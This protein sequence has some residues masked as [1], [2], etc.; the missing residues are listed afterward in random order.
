MRVNDAKLKTANSS[1]DYLAPSHHGRGIMSASIKAV[2][3]WAVQMMNIR[4]IIVTAY[5]GNVASLRVFEK[6]GF[7][8]LDTLVNCRKQAE[9]KG[10]RTY[11]LAVMEWRKPEA[12]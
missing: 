7:T 6:N 4:R 8:H 9:S 10:G 3:E 12:E 11:S 5:A 2:M 1:S